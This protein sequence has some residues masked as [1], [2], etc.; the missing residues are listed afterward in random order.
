MR[1]SAVMSLVAIISQGRVI[2]GWLGVE[3]Q[4][5]TQE[6]A[7]PFGLDVREGIVVSG[8]YREGP[9][10]QAGLQ[11]GDIILRIDQEPVSTGRQAMNQVARANPGQ[12]VRLSILRNGEAMQF[13]AEVGVRPS[14]RG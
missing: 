1:W 3:V 7:E 14:F 11:P 8:L 4:P 5:L 2:R 10:W 6:L 12:K 9:A 13:E